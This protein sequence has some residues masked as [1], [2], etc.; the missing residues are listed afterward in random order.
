VHFLLL[1]VGEDVD[2]QLE[3]F[4]EH[5][6]GEPY[7]V[8]IEPSEIAD[9]AEHYGLEATDLEG[10]ASRSA[11]YF[12]E[13]GSVRDGR[14]IRTSTENPEA[15]FDWYAIGGRW[16][17]CL[18][19][20]APRPVRKFFGLL[21]AGETRSASR[22]RKRE[23]DQEVLLRNPPAALLLRGEWHDSEWLEADSQSVEAWEAAWRERFSRLWAQVPDDALVTAVDIH[24]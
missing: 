1:V 3:P 17:G 6:E 8:E 13:P 19:L 20:A 7:E 21:S 15:Q 2:R 16:E 11:D 4:S 18:E 23:I 9:M 22:A 24:R 14:L 12:A 5:L 10:L